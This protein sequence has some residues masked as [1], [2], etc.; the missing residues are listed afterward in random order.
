MKPPC[1]DHIDN[2]H[3][4]RTTTFAAFCHFEEASP[5]SFHRI[6]NTWWYLRHLRAAQTVRVVHTD[7]SYTKPRCPWLTGFQWRPRGVRHPNSPTHR[8][9]PTVPD[10]IQPTFVFHDS[11]TETLDSRA[12]Y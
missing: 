3:R 4:R 7:F 11:R 5:Q 2:M 12:Q 9:L 6:D 10:A 1:F 8:S